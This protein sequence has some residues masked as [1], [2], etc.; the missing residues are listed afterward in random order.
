MM[1]ALWF[2]FYSGCTFNYYYGPEAW[3]FTIYR[4]FHAAINDVYEQFNI[5][6]V[7]DWYYSIYLFIVGRAP[8]CTIVFGFILSIIS[9]WV[10]WRWNAFITDR[11]PECGRLKSAPHVRT[12]HRRFLS[13]VVVQKS[14]NKQSR[15]APRT[16]THMRST[17][18]SCVTSLDICPL[19]PAP[20]TP[21]PSLTALHSTTTADVC[22]RDD[23]EQIFTFPIP[24]IP[25]QSIP[26]H[27]HIHTDIHTNLYSAK[28]REKESEAPSYS[29][30]QV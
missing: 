26:I 20:Q 24:P 1:Q 7:N 14:L 6:P 17:C 10:Y 29:H 30:S 2:Q 13:V 21:A 8:V 27:I 22:S 5:L 25:I 23:W 15:P 12:F 28:N 18:M 11:Q 4:L 16:H 19:T 3:L 9:L